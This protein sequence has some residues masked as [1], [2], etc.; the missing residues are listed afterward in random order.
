ME[1]FVVLAAA[2]AGALGFALLY[3]VRLRCALPASLL[4]C[5]GWGIYLGATALGAGVFAATML[6]A[7]AMALASEGLSRLMRAPTPLFLLPSLIPLVPGRA[8]YYAMSF[9]VRRDFATA[10][11]FGYA[12]GQMALAI[13]TGTGVVFALF[14]MAAQV[15][16]RWHD[17]KIG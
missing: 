6:A 17:H 5:A 2:F 11:E 3:G 4:G 10:R 12:T 16:K 7:A 8:L 15:K 13:A 9:A 14:Y 1:T